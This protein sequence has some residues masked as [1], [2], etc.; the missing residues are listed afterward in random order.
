MMRAIAASKGETGGDGARAQHEGDVTMAV[1]ILLVP[2]LNCTP[3]IWA[4]QAV[5]LWEQGPVT[6]AD[7]RQGE[8]MAEIAGAILADA[9]PHFVLAGISM[10]GYLA[11]EI[12]RQAQERVLGLGFVDT[13][14]RPDAPEA[15]ERRRAAMTLAR[16]GRFG[17]VVANAFTLAVHERHLAREDLRAIH[18]RM[19]ETVGVAAYLRQQEAIIARPDSRPTLAT[20]TVPT[21]VIVGEGDRLTPPEL[22]LEIAAGIP[23]AELITIRDAGH[24][25]TIEQPEAV[26][27]A[28]SG[29]VARV[30]QVRR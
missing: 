4:P 12:W 5:R 18:T 16:E 11:F 23:G 3:E 20:I 1:P 29:L 15:T 21:T 6:F 2:G 8:T 27:A 9:P 25:S 22:A 30:E 28:L 10:G 13:S 19:S 14:A 26:S 7:T 17:L 24:M